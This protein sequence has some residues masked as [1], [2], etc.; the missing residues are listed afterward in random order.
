MVHLLKRILFYVFLTV[1]VL[2]AVWAYFRLKESKEPKSNVTEH[3]PAD[4]TCLIET[5]TTHELINQLTRQSLIWNSLLTEESCQKAHNG[6]K[7]LDSLI[8]SHE[9]ISNIIEGNSVYWSFMREKNALNHLI[10][11]KLKEQNEDTEVEAFFETVF[12]KNTSMSTFDAY[13]IVINNAKWT[14][15]IE[16]GIVYLS[17][18]LSLLESAVNLKK[19]N[20]ISANATY[21]NLQKTLGEQS[22]I[23]YFNHQHSNFFDQTLFSQQ[24]V[25]NVEV[26]LNEISCNGYS[27][28]D[29]KSF[30]SLLKKQPAESM[31]QITLLPNNPVSVIAISI[32]DAKLFEQN[33]SM[34]LPQDIKEKN[35]EAWK[36]LNDSALY[37]L[38]NEALDNINGQLVTGNYWLEDKPGFVTLLK[39]NDTE[40]A[41]QLLKWIS[42]SSYIQNELTLFRIKEINSS[43][44]SFFN[45]SVK[46]NYACLINNTMY[47]MSDKTMTNYFSEAFANNRLLAKDAG[48]MTYADDNFLQETNF[49]YYENCTEIRK[50]GMPTLFNSIELNTGNEVLSK[51]S[52]TA[53]NYQSFIQ[54]RIN[55]T[56]AKEKTTTETNANALW[57]FAADSSIKTN[58]YIFTNHLTQERELTFQDVNNNLYLINST[59][60]ILFKKK[61][62]EPIQSKIYTV[63]IF[64]NGKLQLLFNTDNYLHLVDRNGVYVQGFPV[65]MPAKITSNITLLDYDNNKDYR[66]FIACTDKKIYNYTLYGVKTE[67]FVPLKTDAEVHLPISYVRVGPSDYLVTADIH[68]KIYAFSRK[69][70][71][72]I[73]FKNKTI[74][75]L[76]HLLV[77]A[78]NN[79][80]NTKL[81][82]VDDKNNLLDKI[83]LSD[84]KEALKLGDEINGFKASFDLMDDDNQEDVLVYGNGAF[85]GYDLFS[86]KLIESFNDQAV[87]EDVQVINTSNHQWLLAYDKA[88]Q[89]VEIIGM[90]GKPVSAINQVNQKPLVS[91]LYKN[92][93]TYVVTIGGNKVSCQELN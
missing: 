58:A 72:R 19:E 6:I 55:G 57:T 92:G 54:F 18:D 75:D 29:E 52:L 44:F 76:E 26:Q 81:I 69:G 25:F 86:S 2:A 83:S 13:D 27:L 68:G 23:V 5:K 71:G 36:E 14:A 74:E 45:A 66:L 77:K 87:Y 41:Q 33:T 90:D 8:T 12:K 70:E 17:S 4:V 10:Q 65:K 7:Y 24:S 91:D 63:D 60:N 50:T 37:P 61:I 9:A 28:A 89:K 39:I 85:Y 3:I 49:V 51:L 38:K 62:D 80:D 84:K 93:K 88:T 43:L 16:K 59:G 32:G 31:E 48:F 73:D 78:G 34:R 82:Y 64:K 67:G 22:T 30:F 35:E 15:C 79:L 46:N 40:K 1:S 42:D 56:H 47:L 53:K 21:L 20:S 11:F